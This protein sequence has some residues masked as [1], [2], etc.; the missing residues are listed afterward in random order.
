MGVTFY[1][2]AGEDAKAQLGAL[3]EA[4]LGAGIKAELLESQTQAGLF[5]LVCD[6]DDLTDDLTDNLTGNPLV[7]APP[8]AK[9][10]QFRRVE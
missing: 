3:A 8:N 4:L 10:W 6:T 9:V 5:L 2:L 1:E 7:T